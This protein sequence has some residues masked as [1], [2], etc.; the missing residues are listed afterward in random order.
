MHNRIPNCGLSHTVNASEG[1]FRSFQQLGY[2][3]LFHFL[4]RT[5][6]S[7]EDLSHWKLVGN[8]NRI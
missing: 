3:T 2:G 4:L 5:K 8:E 6:F 1:M 7:K